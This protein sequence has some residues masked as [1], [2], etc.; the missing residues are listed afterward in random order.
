[1]IEVS[2]KLDN[3]VS[4]VSPE[5]F[6]DFSGAAEKSTVLL[7]INVTGEYLYGNPA[8]G[9]TFSQM[10]ADKGKID[11]FV[12]DEANFNSFKEKKPFK[13]VYASQGIEKLLSQIELPE[14]RNW[15]F[16]FPAQD[17]VSYVEYTQISFALKVKEEQAEEEM[18]AEPFD[19][20]AGEEI[21]EEDTAQSDV[22]DQAVTAKKSGG[23]SIFSFSA[24][25]EFQFF[26]IFIFLLV[27]IV[28]RPF[29]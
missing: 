3:A 10:I 5:S 11:I 26:M 13:A 9:A 24:I 17:R 14:D 12:V 20:A 2:K 1:V 15:Y 8:A 27:Y 28:V 25:D 7:D 21:S 16:I 29:T 18:D 19:D 6:E 4:F 22:S 23:C